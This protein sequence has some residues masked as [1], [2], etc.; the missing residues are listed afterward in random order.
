MIA[1]CMEFLLNV[2]VHMAVLSAI[3]TM[4]G[5]GQRPEVRKS[6]ASKK[7]KKSAKQVANSHSS[8][9]A[10][11]ERG[12]SKSAKRRRS[13]R[14]I[15]NDNLA[16]PPPAEADATQSSKSSKKRDSQC[17]AKSPRS[18]KALKCV[19]ATLPTL[20]VEPS[21]LRWT[22]EGGTRTIRIS[23]LTNERQAMKVKC[24]DNY[25]YS[26]DPVYTFVEPGSRISVEVVRNNGALKLD[27][28]VFVTTK[29]KADDQHAKSLFMGK[30]GNLAAIVPLLSAT[31]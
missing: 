26:V 8:R 19:P 18:L 30:K 16:E 24:S 14:S 9:V 1:F 28:M 20:A 7:H 25:L 3:C 6:S 21:D 27:E 17:F 23:N 29:A 5:S 4:C 2:M 12:S 10:K 11:L 22:E 15:N 31:A 13:D